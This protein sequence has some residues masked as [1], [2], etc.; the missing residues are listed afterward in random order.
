MSDEE[1]NVGAGSE[2]SGETTETEQSE[3]AATETAQ[4]ETADAEGAADAP[5]AGSQCTC[6]DGRVGTLH[7]LGGQMVCLPNQG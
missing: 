4:A 7:D 1:T 3:T 2:T 5:Q 6:P